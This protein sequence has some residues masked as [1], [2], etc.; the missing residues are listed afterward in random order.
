M[1][2]N[3]FETMNW[4]YR[5]N[6]LGLSFTQSVA[7]GYYESDRWSEKLFLYGRWLF[8]RKEKDMGNPRGAALGYYEK[9]LWS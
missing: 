6:N 5:P 7:L 9:D 3:N 4:S 1:S 8:W 2:L